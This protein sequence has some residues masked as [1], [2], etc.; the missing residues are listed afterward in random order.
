M[1]AIYMHLEVAQQFKPLLTLI[2]LKVSFSSV[3]HS[4]AFEIT[5]ELE[6]FATYVADYLTQSVTKQCSI[7]FQPTSQQRMA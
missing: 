7:L 6:V 2:T 1:K 5:W 4:M 3:H